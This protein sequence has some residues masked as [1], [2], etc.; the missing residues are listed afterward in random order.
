MCKQYIEFAIKHIKSLVF[1]LAI[2]CGGIAFMWTLPLRMNNCEERLGKLENR[3]YEDEK[4]FS[5][6]AT[7]LEATL[8]QIQTDIQ[9]IKQRLL[10]K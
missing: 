6:T 10:S 3:L 2:I 8:L 5:L 1:V 4:E 9:L 7:R